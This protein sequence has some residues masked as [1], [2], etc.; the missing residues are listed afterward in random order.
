M[1]PPA[2][3]VA[4]TYLLPGSKP[5]MATTMEP[6]PPSL[7]WLEEPLDDEQ[8]EAEIVA[9]EERT[10]DR[11]TPVD[12]DDETATPFAV[13]DERSAE[14]AMRKLAR[15]RAE[16][17]RARE[18]AAGWRAEV[19]E[20]L[21]A[22]ERRLGRSADYFDGL[23]AEYLRE[24][25]EDDPKRASIALPSGRISSRKVPA[26]V[27]VTDAAQVI[28]WAETD[29]DDDDRAALLK[30]ETK[31]VAKELKRLSDITVET[32]EDSEPELVARDADTGKRIPGT[33]VVRERWSIKVEPNL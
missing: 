23:L 20:Y 12:D 31:I 18:L 3:I 27:E 6:I 7:G 24:V 4:Y 9:G 26:R 16:I 29:L 15:Y 28:E 11:A 13:H 14:W 30:I 17:D 2:G 5:T 8:I 10:A 19:D 33:S 25:R 21:A 32:L 22:E 1:S